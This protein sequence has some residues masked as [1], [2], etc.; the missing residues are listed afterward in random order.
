[1]PQA[2]GQQDKT[3]HV[4][5]FRHRIDSIAL[6]LAGLIG[7][8]IQFQLSPHYNQNAIAELVQ[9]GGD[10]VDKASLEFSE[11]IDQ[12]GRGSHDYFR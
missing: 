4:I 8:D 3:I 11:R 12:D 10:R 2:S 5:A 1:M 7:T 9:R 6:V